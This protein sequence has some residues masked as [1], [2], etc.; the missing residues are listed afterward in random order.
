MRELTD[1]RVLCAPGGWV[2]VTRP[3][4]DTTI[5]MRLRSS[6]NGAQQRLNV[7]TVVMASGEP[8]SAHAW[9]Y[10]PF[11]S[12]ERTANNTQGI[13][14]D[15]GWNEYREILLS[16]ASDEPFGVEQLERHF[17]T[18][19]QLLEADDP[20]VFPM[21][22]G[23]FLVGTDPEPGEEPAPLIKPTGRITDEF[24]AHLAK[25]YQWLVATGQSAPSAV[26]AEQ[27]GAPV[28][29]V[30]RWVATARQREL[31]PPG[32]PGRAG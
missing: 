12:V 28:A 31:L 23:M 20:E 1:W 15:S 2:R 6:G 21:P 5:Y 13:L 18:P 4:G 25:M 22:R 32:R 8:I 7:H 30:R 26:I 27:T 19:E 17:G 24:L 29:T 14:T 11:E 9:R 16:P 10:V 3:A